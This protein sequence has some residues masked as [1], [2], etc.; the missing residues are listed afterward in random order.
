MAMLSK[1]F[2][3]LVVLAA[4]AGVALCFS[5]GPPAQPLVCVNISP[6][7]TSHGAAASA[8]NGGYVIA[9]TLDLTSDSPP[10]Y[11]YTAGDTYDGEKYVGLA[12]FSLVS[13][14]LA[15]SGCF[16]F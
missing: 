16:V 5:T 11:N 7:P 10:M 4:S 6:N 3:S 12:S 2:L 8:E 13:A 15:N 1:S 9:T 14:Y